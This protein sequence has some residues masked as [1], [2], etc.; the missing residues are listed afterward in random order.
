[1]GPVLLS[2][3]LCIYTVKFREDRIARNQMVSSIDRKRSLYN[4]P[5]PVL[6]TEDIKLCEM[7]ISCP[8]GVLSCDM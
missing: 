3:Y 5:N 8:K 7:Y 6:G 1:M 4:A 2:A